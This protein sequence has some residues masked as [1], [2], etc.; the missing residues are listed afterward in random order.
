M[1]TTY[2]ITRFPKSSSIGDNVCLIATKNNG[3]DE[4]KVS[5]RDIVGYIK[6]EAL[7]MPYTYGGLVITMVDEYHLIVDLDGEPLL[8]I[9]EIEEVEFPTLPMQH[10]SN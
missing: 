7:T 1:K 10:S 8:E 3:Y 4:T 2:K 9:M 6:C 5:L